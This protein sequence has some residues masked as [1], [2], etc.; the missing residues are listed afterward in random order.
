MPQASVAWLPNRSSR[1]MIDTRQVL[2]V[3]VTRI[4]TSGR[5]FL[6]GSLVDL[7][8]GLWINGERTGRIAHRLL[9]DLHAGA[10]WACL[11]DL[12]QTRDGIFRGQMPAVPGN[13]RYL[14]AEF[15]PVGRE[16]RQ[17][18]DIIF[19]DDDD[20][21]VL[22]DVNVNDTPNELHADTYRRRLE[23][24]GPLEDPADPADTCP[25]CIRLDFAGP[26]CPRCGT[27]RPV[28]E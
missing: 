25:R 7:E 17:V 22:E 19:M 9:Q 20:L 10:T 13:V 8:G 18:I 23:G 26:A 12:V 5:R 21:N 6:H 14:Q 24:A 15:A 1:T 28:G 2:D 3:D 16:F 11:V 4:H 27:D